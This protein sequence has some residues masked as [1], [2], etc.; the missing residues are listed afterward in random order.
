M[1]ADRVQSLTSILQ[2][3]AGAAASHDQNR[4]NDPQISN[5]KKDAC[6][7]PLYPYR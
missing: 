1:Q 5:K 6:I 2:P 4:L 3:C 7:R